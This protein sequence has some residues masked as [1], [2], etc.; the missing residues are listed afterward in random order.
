MSGTSMASPNV[1]GMGALLAGKHTDW[2]PVAIK[3]APTASSS[4]CAAAAAISSLL[5][6]RLSPNASTPST[7][8]MRIGSPSSGE[9][10]AT[11]RYPVPVASAF[12]DATDAAFAAAMK[13]SAFCSASSASDAFSENVSRA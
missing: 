4:A 12:A 9:R 3:S 13:G 6:A 11:A 1:A 8:S 5:S 2:S 10:I 7:A